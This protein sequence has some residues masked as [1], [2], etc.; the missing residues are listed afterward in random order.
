MRNIINRLR[1]IDWRR[2]SGSML[3]CVMITLVGLSFMMLIM[4]YNGVYV[5]ATRAQTR[6]DAIAD[7]AAAY[8]VTYDHQFN[9]REAYEMAALLIAYNNTDRSPMTASAEVY[10]AEDR[11]NPGTLLPNKRIKVTVTAESSFYVIDPGGSGDRRYGAGGVSTVE[12]VR[13]EDV[14]IIPGW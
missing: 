12:A 1:G 2:G 3:I 9:P 10:A 5:T 11:Q 8:S 13:P 6:A 4:E 14:F 7:S